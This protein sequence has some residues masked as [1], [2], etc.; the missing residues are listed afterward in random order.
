MAV[1]EERSGYMAVINTLYYNAY[2]YYTTSYLK[3]GQSRYD[4]HKVSEL[5]NVYQT[6]V[7]INQETPVYKIDYTDANRRIAVDLKESAR[8]LKNLISELTNGN[9]ERLFDRKMAVSEDESI[10]TAR[11]I[12]EEATG[13][14][15]GFSLE[16]KSLA[17]SQVN[18]GEFIPSEQLS[19]SPNTYSFDVN[20]NG[21]DYEFQIRVSAEDTNAGIQEKIARM[22][23]KSGIG[24]TASVEYR[25]GDTL[26]SAICITSQL[27]GRPDGSAE[28]FQISDDRS[29]REKGLVSL[30][31]IG[32]ITDYPKD[33]EIVLNGKEYLTP[34]NTFTKGQSFEISLHDVSEPGKAV[35]IGFV[36]DMEAVSHHVTAFV[37]E[38]NNFLE[39]VRNYGEEQSASR[40]LVRDYTTVV[41][42]YRN[43]LESLGLML[44][45]DGS[46]KVDSSLLCQATENKETYKE[47]LEQLTDFKNALVRVTNR[48][49][50]DPMEYI[51]K[52]IVSYKNPRNVYNSPYSCSVYSG[53]LFNSYC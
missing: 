47:S 20:M 10:V 11:Y 35:E 6:M 24:I 44:N 37:D 31:G 38:Y 46:L 22:I 25:Q 12:G 48:A 15:E 23:N 27:T 51:D 29:S 28:Y 4:A 50:I 30:L 53:M 43:D 18:A 36:T 8:G 26:T 40:K 2:N 39:K 13:E 41:K 16:V 9:T 7:K 14:P 17:A 42:T 33:G 1:M 34:T 19:L 52:V 5:R 32:K 45:G 21:V 3:K 49:M